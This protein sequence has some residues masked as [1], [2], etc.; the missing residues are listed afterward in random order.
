MSVKNIRIILIYLFIFLY[1]NSLFL[2]FLAL[3]TEILI[4]RDIS[5]FKIMLELIFIFY[6]FL[7]F[8]K[9]KNKNFEN[10]IKEEELIYDFIKKENK[11]Y[12]LD[13]FFLDIIYLTINNP[14]IFLISTTI[15]IFM[16][17]LKIIYLILLKLLITYIWTLHYF[18]LINTYKYFNIEFE[19]SLDLK[20]YNYFW[21]KKGKLISLYFV[22]IPQLTAFLINY[23]FLS[24]NNKKIVSVNLLK[25]VLYYR[26]LGVPLKLIIMSLKLIKFLEKILKSVQWSN[27]KKSR[28]ASIFLYNIKWKFSVEVNKEYSFILYWSSTMKI[29]KSE[30]NNQINKILCITTYSQYK[31]IYDWKF[32]NFYR[33]QYCNT[34]EKPHCSLTPKLS[35]NK[36]LNTFAL[37]KTHSEELTDY[38][39]KEKIEPFMVEKNLEKKGLRN[40]YTYMSILP[41]EKIKEEECSNSFKLNNGTNNFIL[42]EVSKKNN[43]IKAKLMFKEE[44]KILLHHGDKPSIGDLDKE[45]NLNYATSKFVNEDSKKA[46]EELND[47]IKIEFRD[48]NEKERNDVR[49]II[50]N[51]ISKLNKEEFLDSVKQGAK[52]MGDSIVLEE[53]ENIKENFNIK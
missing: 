38:K 10:I 3:L 49:D 48:L 18:S 4:L 13:L 8:Y 50:I 15:L 25:K 12:T 32:L 2:F 42:E 35:H 52:E 44:K 6:L 34:F 39:T 26:V 9:F 31:N 5:E 20:N 47:L 22:K 27:K 30:L 14:L 53:I 37:I 16:I 7:S 46:K 19:I 51:R 23:F 28:W 24:Q 33:Y 40:Q 45:G 11:L 21:L 29:K 36:N 43:I 1:I 17:K 41:E